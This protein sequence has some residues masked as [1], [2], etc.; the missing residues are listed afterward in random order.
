M[1]IVWLSAAVVTPR[2]GR[3]IEARLDGD[4]RLGE[5]AADTRR[6]KARDRLHFLG[7]LVGDR[8]QLL[9]I[10]AAE[11]EHDVARFAVRSAAVLG[12]GS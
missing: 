5:L 4:F 11:I 9:R 1:R 8:G 12:S 7:D 6:A 10:V 2:F 3:E